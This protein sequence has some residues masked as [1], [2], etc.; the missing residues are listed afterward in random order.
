MKGADYYFGNDFDYAYDDNQNYFG[1]DYS[2]QNDYDL[3][4]YYDANEEYTQTDNDDFD[5][6]GYAYYFD[7]TNTQFFVFKTNHL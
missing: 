4:Q 1:L 6:Y 2:Q 7:G 5:Y 3:S